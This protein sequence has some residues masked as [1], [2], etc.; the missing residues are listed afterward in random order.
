MKRLATVALAVLFVASLS[1]AVHAE[2][3][4]FSIHGSVDLLCGYEENTGDPTSAVTGIGSSGNYN[5]VEQQVK[6]DVDADM[7]DNVSVHIGLEQTGVWG[8][9][10]TGNTA[11]NGTYGAGIDD[12]SV[13]LNVE[14]AYVVVKE[15]IIEQV[16]VKAGVQNI[17]YSLRGDGNAMFLSVPEI[18]AWKVTVNYDP[19]YVDVIIAKMIET[20][21]TNGDMDQDLIALAIEYF[22]ENKGKVQC[23]VFTVSDEDADISLVEYSVGVTYLVMDD[24]EVFVQIGGQSGEWGDG[25]DTGCMAYNLGAEWT[26]SK[27]SRKPYVGVS[28]QYFGGDDTDANWVNLGDVDETIVLEADRNLR[29][30]NRGPNAKLL[31]DNYSVIR[32]V[33]GAVIDDKTNVDAGLGMFTSVDDGANAG[34]IA[35]GDDS[36]GMELD[37][38]VT[39]K[40]TDDLTVGAGVGY[41]ASGD[42]IENCNAAGDDEALIAGYLSATLKF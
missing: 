38:A 4:V 40:L 3:T 39:H 19:L 29:D 30:H 34:L 41:V 9:D 11:Y 35:A 14:E 42:A 24:L 33:G 18:G 17:E 7:T 28:Y 16:S 10:E 1:S 36:I 13:A 22:L 32:V 15:L 31:T 21:N 26:F 23:I 27:I 12:A 37:V 2:R 25:N 20:A 5:R 8:N 6:L